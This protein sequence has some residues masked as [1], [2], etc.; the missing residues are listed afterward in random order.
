MEW[1]IIGNWDGVDRRRRR[2]DLGFGLALFVR[3][4]VLPSRLVVGYLIYS[5][6]A[7][8]SDD[9]GRTMNFELGDGRRSIMNSAVSVRTEEAAAQAS[10]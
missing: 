9:I 4:P 3:P 1:E 2:I 8:T 5:A 10:S 7:A 6:P